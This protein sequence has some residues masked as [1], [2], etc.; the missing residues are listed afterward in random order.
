MNFLVFPPTLTCFSPLDGRVVIKLPEDEL[1]LDD[2]LLELLDELLLDEELLL[3]L[4]EELLELD[5]EADGCAPHA[6]KPTL[7]K[8]IA[9]PIKP[10]F[11]DVLL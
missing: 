8:I 1:L 5:E 7:K 2:E 11:I 10:R 3:E 6:I 4:L 9:A